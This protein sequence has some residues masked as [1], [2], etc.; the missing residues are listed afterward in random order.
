MLKPAF[1]FRSEAKE[2]NKRQARIDEWVRT[3]ASKARKIPK[4]RIWNP[5]FFIARTSLRLSSSSS[6]LLYSLV[7]EL[8]CTALHFRTTYWALDFLL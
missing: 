5:E 3:D 6:K 7:A 2:G 4:K 8:L 1:P